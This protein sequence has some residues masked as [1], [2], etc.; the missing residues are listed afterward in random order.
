MARMNTTSGDNPFFQ[1]W[2]GPFGVPEFSRV[3]TEHFMPAYER[4]FA[5][6]MAE[7][8][9]IAKDPAPPTFENTILAYEEAGRMLERVEVAIIERDPHAPFRIPRHGTGLIQRCGLESRV[10]QFLH[11]PREEPGRNIKAEIGRAHV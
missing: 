1:P 2:T 5:E 9:A 11:L 6:H 4:A 10:R 8:D 7:I 3:K